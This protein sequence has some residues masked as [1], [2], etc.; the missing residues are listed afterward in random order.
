M[1]PTFSYALT[2]GP[3][4]P[5]FQSFAPVGTTDMVNL[6]DGDFTYNIPLMEVGG[7]PINISYNSGIT[8]DQEATTVGLGWNINPGVI[9]R[10]V[11]S[12][13]DDF[14]GFKDKIVKEFNMKENITV[15]VSAKS[16]LELF[17]K[18]LKNPVKNITNVGTKLGMNVGFFINNYWGLGYEFG[19]SPS[20]SAGKK[21][22]LNL[23]AGL[24]LG[25]NSKKGANF[26]PSLSYARNMMEKNAYALSIDAG[27]N[28]REGLKD[29]SLGYD[30]PDGSTKK[31]KLN[32]LIT[33]MGKGSMDFSFAAE[34]FVPN[35]SMP[36]Q[37]SSFTLN[38]KPGVAIFGSQKSPVD[39]SGYVSTQ[40]LRHN[41]VAKKPYGLLYSHMGKDDEN[42]L[43]DFN[44]EKDGAFYDYAVNLPIVNPGYDVL[45]LTGQGIGGSYQLKRSDVPMFFDAKNVSLSVGGALGYEVGGGITCNNIINISG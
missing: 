23:T 45:S 8:Q 36:Q 39:F 20:F 4:Q 26:S 24:G 6:P 7:Y 43:M 9:N 25:V 17:G 29:L 11:R 1:A 22:E 13:P 19:V 31:S 21:S 40:T 14:K 35:I 16:S 30:A 27:E 18:E 3:S 28:S 15:G 10:N 41:R 32:K 42:S 33:E 34:T 12:L 37:S 5:E 44:R 2:G 38:L